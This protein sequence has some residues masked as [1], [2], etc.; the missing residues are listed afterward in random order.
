MKKRW[1]ELEKLAHRCE[2]RHE[3]EEATPFGPTPT[4]PPA[5][6]SWGAPPAP[7]S[8]YGAYGYMPPPPPP[9]P[10]PNLSLFRTSALEAE[11]Y[12]R[13]PSRHRE[14]SV[15]RESS[16]SMTRFVTPSPAL[17]GSSPVDG[18]IA[19]YVDWIKPKMHDRYI[20]QLEDA[21]QKLLDEGYTTR[22]VQ[23]W[24]G[25]DYEHKWKSLEIPPGIGRSLARS[26]AQFGRE[27]EQVQGP[28]HIGSRQISRL[29]ERP[30]PGRNRQRMRTSASRPP[31]STEGRVIESIESDNGVDLGDYIGDDD[32][33][34]TGYFEDTQATQ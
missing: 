23:G 13:K 2:K 29:P 3:K 16:R 33:S 8:S 20:R 1:E 25:D 6:H 14:R 30:S 4:P 9:T 24:K 19:E 7:Y 34:D 32:L 31:A 28:G 18:D 12:V 22:D 26:V 5:P 27:R 21:K 17:R 15:T 10:L 11:I